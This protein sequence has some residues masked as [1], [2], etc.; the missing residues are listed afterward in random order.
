M[1][2]SYGKDPASHPDPES[3]V[4]DRKGA[5]EALTGAHAG[6]PSSCEI[7]SSGVPT[8]LSEA[9]GHIEG[10]ARGEPSP[11]PA[12]SKTL[13]MRGNSP[14]G[15]REI[16]QVPTEFA[17][18]GR[19]EKANGRA[20]GVHAWGKSDDCV[21]PEKP[22]N[23]GEPVSP[24]EAVEGRRSTKGSMRAEAASRTQSRIDA[25]RS[26]HRARCPRITGPPP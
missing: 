19:P 24:A 15:K 14:H 12:Q 8:P 4:G 9:E 1:Q 11:D 5:G 6:Q 13:C 3:C 21:V 20:S 17:S 18:M 26:R 2:E 23:K 10:G 7:R 16:P 22:P 25:L